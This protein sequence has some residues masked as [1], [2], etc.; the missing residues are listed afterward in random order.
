MAEGK[1]VAVGS[2]EV[3]GVAITLVSGVVEGGSRLFREGSGGF[4]TGVNVRGVNVAGVKVGSALT[5]EPVQQS[6]VPLG[7]VGKT[8]EPRPV[9]FAHQGD[10]QLLLT[11]IDP[12]KQS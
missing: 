5:C 3:T 4:E 11:D 1:E 10:V 8:L 9:T 12:Q 2:S 7:G 6:S